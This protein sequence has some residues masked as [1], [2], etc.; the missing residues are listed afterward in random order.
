M[1]EVGI[2]CID[3]KY[4]HTFECVAPGASPLNFNKLKANSYIC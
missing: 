3:Q 4:S 2:G 1:L